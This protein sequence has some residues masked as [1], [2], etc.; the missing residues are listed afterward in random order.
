MG[1]SRPLWRVLFLI[2]LWPATG[3][4]AQVGKQPVLPLL[5]AE[6]A[7]KLRLLEEEWQIIDAILTKRQALSTRGP[8]I[9]VRSP[10]VQLTKP[11]PTIETTTPVNLS[12]HFIEHGAPVQLETLEVCGKS[13]GFQRCF[14]DKLKPYLNAHTNSL[15]VPNLDIPTGKYVIEIRIADEKGQET[16]AF[17]KMAVVEA[18]KPSD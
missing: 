2:W 18:P 3:G 14:T 7:E 4:D 9:A 6:E 17:Y 1:T 16:V 12:V 11:I 15:D 5:T 10:S 8:L 13:W